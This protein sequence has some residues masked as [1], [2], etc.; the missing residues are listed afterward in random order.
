RT[1]RSA[2]NDESVLRS[3]LFAPSAD[4]YASLCAHPLTAEWEAL[5]RRAARL[6]FMHPQWICA[7]WRAFSAPGERLALWYVRRNAGE[8]K[9]RLIALLP[10]IHSE[11]T[12]RL[13]LNYHTPQAELLAESD[14]PAVALLRV[15]LA[16]GDAPQTILPALDPLGSGPALCQRGALASG[17]RLLALPHECACFIPLE[18]G[19]A[20]Y[21]ARLGKDVG[22]DVRRRRRR[23]QELG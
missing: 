15:L 14:S 5:A 22:A 20:A 18:Q 17:H 21:A 13:A 4:G 11:D 19:W 3:P 7:W 8:D 12:L 2:D 9:G 10:V 6:P 16:E 23:L 1:G